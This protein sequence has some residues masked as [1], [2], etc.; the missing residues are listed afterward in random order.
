MAQRDL[1]G[2]LIE[3]LQP[4]SKLELIPLRFEEHRVRMILIKGEPWWVGKEV[5]VALTIKNASDAVSRLDDDEKS[6]VGISDPHGRE[7]MTTVVNEAGLWSLVLSSTKPDAKRFKR[8]LTH[9]VLPSIRKTGT[10]S[11]PKLTRL[12][13]VQRRLKSDRR[14]A[15]KRIEVI[16][17]NKYSGARLADAGL[18][19]RQFP[20]WFDALNQAQF[21][22]KTASDLRKWL[23][24]KGWQTPLDHMGEIPLS[25]RS[26]AICLAERKIQEAEAI[27]GR[28]LSIDD[29][30][31]IVHATVQ[32]VVASSFDCLGPDHGFSIRDDRKRG[33]VLDVVRSLPAA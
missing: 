17:W 12:D 3:E 5:C 29:Q 10:Y 33:K 22:G 8:W 21:N 18:G 32:H 25:Q 24:L 26:H 15:E 19:R 20:A 31:E 28:T 2:E 4:A 27:S 9:E 23:G 30:L 14:T 16:D 6:V 1:F 11:L 13:K 7:Q